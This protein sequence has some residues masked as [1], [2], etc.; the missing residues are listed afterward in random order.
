MDWLAWLLPPRD[1]HATFV[2]SLHHIVLG[3]SP[4][5]IKTLPKKGTASSSYVPLGV[6]HQMGGASSSPQVSVPPQKRSS[7]E[8]LCVVAQ[9]D[10]AAF[11]M[12]TVF[13]RTMDVAAPE[14]RAQLFGTLCKVYKRPALKGLTFVRGHRMKSAS[15]EH[16]CIFIFEITDASNVGTDRELLKKWFDSLIVDSY[17]TKELHK[18]SQHGDT[19]GR[20]VVKE[21][22]PLLDKLAKRE[23]QKSR[24]ILG[25]V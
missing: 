10:D 18:Q 4:K 1:T 17:T 8:H 13:C 19:S 25:I 11:I 23:R 15:Y 2:T 21:M 24:N 5:K 7:V 3:H 6:L 9:D 12:S 16:P 22:K 20:P 14:L